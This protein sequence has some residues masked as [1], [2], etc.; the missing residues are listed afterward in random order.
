MIEDPLSVAYETSYGNTIPSSA[1]RSAVMRLGRGE[2]WQ[3]VAYDEF[4]DHLPEH[5]ED[6]DEAN[7]LLNY[8]ESVVDDILSRHPDLDDLE[9]LELFTSDRASLG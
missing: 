6:L 1:I 2:D 8:C 9:V 3:R 5:D 4:R 7:E